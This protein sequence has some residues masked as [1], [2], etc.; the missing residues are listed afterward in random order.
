MKKFFSVSTATANALKNSNWLMLEKVITMPVALLVNVILARALGVENLG[1][2]S[3]LMSLVFLVSP[4]TAMGLSSLVTRELVNYPENQHTIL[5]ASWLGRMAG[6]FIGALLLVGYAWFFEAELLQHWIVWLAVAQLFSSLSL[7]DF[8]FQYRVEA[9]YSAFARLSNLL[10]FALL[11]LLFAWQGATLQVFVFL[12]A[13]ELACSGLLFLLFYQYRGGQLRQWKLEVAE[14]KRLLKQSYWLI[15]SGFAAVIY[16]KVDMVMLKQLSG[17]SEV[18]I[19]AVASRLSEVWYFIPTALVASF[20]PMLLAAKKTDNSNYIVKLQKLNDGL[21]ML[22]AIVVIVVWLLGEWVIT[23]L[24]G[25][26]YQAAAQVLTIHIFAGVFIFMRALLSKWLIAEHLL[27]YSLFTQGT[28]ALI[29]VAIN[30]ALIPGL[31]AVGAA[32]ATLISYACA[33]YVVLWFFPKLQ[34]MAVVMTKSI[35]SP[36][37]YVLFAVKKVLRI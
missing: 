5:G 25:V 4:L 23:L 22:A 6:A 10:V 32:W 26:D 35:F 30:L 27:K 21:F 28:G 31:G 7:L 9:K 12:Y 2:Y 15:L 3:Y 17:A 16:L 19:Y 20:F 24:Y 33:S 36:L 14:T 8:W 1:T 34:P 13:L 37:R 29:N 11:K 18:G